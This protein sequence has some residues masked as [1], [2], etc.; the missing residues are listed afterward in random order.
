MKC[1]EHVPI[2][3]T[4]WFKV[5]KQGRKHADG[6][7]WAAL[8]PSRMPANTFYIEPWV[9]LLAQGFLFCKDGEMRIGKIR[10]YNIQSWKFK[11]RSDPEHD[12]I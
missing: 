1:K 11:N 4:I 3:N 9:S 2:P 8:R 7:A 6:T 5:G 12:L 10:T